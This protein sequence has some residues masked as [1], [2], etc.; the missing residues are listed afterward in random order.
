MLQRGVVP[1][2]NFQLGAADTVRSSNAYIRVSAVG[3]DDTKGRALV[4]AEYLQRS[5][6]RY[7]GGGR[8]YFLEKVNG[9]W[10]EVR[11]PPGNTCGFD[12]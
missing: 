3:F 8:Y 5:G 1:N 12:I 6:T 11:V 7:G 4:Y 9:S 2:W 10:T